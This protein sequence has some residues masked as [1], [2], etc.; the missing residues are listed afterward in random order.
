[1]T[2]TVLGKKYY[3]RAALICTLAAFFYIYEFTVRTMPTAMTGELMRDFGIS[4]AGLGVLSS[5]FYWGYV[6]MQIPAGLLCDRFGVRPILTISMGLCTAGTFIFGLSNNI[7]FA[8]AAFLIIGV[9]SS[10]AFVGALVL[11]ARWFPAKHFAMLVGLV[12]FLGCLGAIVGVGPIVLLVARINW[13]GTVNAF[14]IIGIFITV[15]M[16]IFIRNQPM[17]QSQAEKKQ[18]KTLAAQKPRFTEIQRLKMVCMNKQVWLVGL[19]AFAIWGPIVVFAGLWGL[20]F[21]VARYQI[22]SASAS[23][24]ISILWLGIAIGGPLFGWW[25]NHVDRRCLPL[26]LCALL[27]LISAILVIYVDNLSWTTTCVMLF[28]LGAA[29]AGQTLSFGVIQDISH[30]EVVG[31]GVGF[32]NMAVV[33]GGIFLQ[34]IAGFILKL[35]WDGAM[36]NGAPIYSLFDYRLAL[37][38]VPACGLIALLTPLFWIKETGCVL[39]HTP[40]GSLPSEDAGLSSNSFS[41]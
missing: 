24:G 13:H 34:P 1:M 28:F 23:V 29:A 6:F 27:G 4:A 5:M 36:E 33:F 31:T 32:N 14:V 17:R 25:S 15:L 8:D 2:Q 12:Q 7:Y 9:A 16:G 41:H 19:Y 39:Q 21:L 37:L 3:M 35:H 30:P 40:Q 10:T 20:P 26:A 22:D 11:V 18:E 38:S